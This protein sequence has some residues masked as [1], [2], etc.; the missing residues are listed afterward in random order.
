MVEL[1]GQMIRLPVAVCVF[2]AREMTTLME[3]WVPLGESS[4]GATAPRQEP[5]GEGFSVRAAVDRGS[6]NPARGAAALPLPDSKEEDKVA[7]T[8][9]GDDMVKLVEYS[10]ITVK[11]GQGEG[12]DHSGGEQE[13]DAGRK[14]ITDNLTEDAFVTWVV[15]DFLKDEKK[16]KNLPDSDRK[17]LRVY[18]NVLKRWPREELHFEEDQLAELRGIKEAILAKK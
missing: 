4:S 6:T 5:L 9:L 11:R 3:R 12:G 15:A 1:F 16:G 17:Y 10:I 7:D 8:H 18:Y 13:L 2:A 14:V